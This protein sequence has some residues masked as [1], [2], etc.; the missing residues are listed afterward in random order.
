MRSLALSM[1]QLRALVAIRV[2]PDGV[3]AVSSVSGGTWATAPYFFVRRSSEE[4]LGRA[5][6]PELLSMEFLQGTPPLLA[7]GLNV[8]LNAMVLRQ[9]QSTYAR[10]GARRNAAVCRRRLLRDAWPRAIGQ[11]VL[12]PYGLDKDRY[13]AASEA[14]VGR[15]V[16]QN[17]GLGAVQFVTPRQDRPATLV[18]CAALLAPLGYTATENNTVSLQMSPDYIG[19]PF[20]PKQ[21]GANG[22]V[23]YV[24]SAFAQGRRLG[25]APAVTP[26]LLVGGGLVEAFA[27][28]G[29]APEGRQDGR[30]GAPQAVGA[31]ERPF[32]L[33]FAIGVGSDSLADAFTKLPAQKYNLEVPYWPVTRSAS[34]SQQALPYELGDGG[35]LENFGL[36]PMMQSRVRKVAVFVNTKNPVTRD[37]DLCAAAVGSVD[38]TYA[39]E[40]RLSCLFGHCR[41]SLIER[42]TGSAAKNQVFKS[43]DYAPLLCHFQRLIS[44]GKP[45]VVK[46]KLKVVGNTWWGIQGDW[47]IE[48]IWVYNEV[49]ADF[50]RKLPQDTQRE[51][52]K[53]RLGPFGRLAGFPFFKTALQNPP[54]I[55]GYSWPQINLL[56]AQAEYAVLQHQHLFCSTFKCQ[57]R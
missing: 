29:R 17:P 15:I 33:A 40:F 5:A 32:S 24:K 51:L 9:I 54:E 53:G 21:S 3:D 49:I 38:L 31:P 23:H 4:L 25:V 14:D 55:F 45:I 35:N 7:A 19:S 28:G 56:A 48:V 41:E 52:F 22:K 18:M 1:G 39:A 27:F 8:S 44:A 11:A 13:M 46:R 42:A 26:A 10:C 2:L 47:D 37:V 36:L 20:Y 12:G 57:G 50:E 43:E 16:Q 34:E 30:S 6:T